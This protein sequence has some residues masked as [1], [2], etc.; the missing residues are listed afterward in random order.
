M[1]E[2][3]SLA[4]GIMSSYRQ[5]SYEPYDEEIKPERKRLHAVKK[6]NKPKKVNLFKV[7]FLLLFLCYA[8]FPVFKSS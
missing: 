1:L 4:W 6:H 8:L 7:A 2:E 5:Y 3:I